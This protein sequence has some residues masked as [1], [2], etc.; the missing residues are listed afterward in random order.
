MTCRKSRARIVELQPLETRDVPS[1]VGAGLLCGCP[2]CSGLG[3]AGLLAESAGGAGPAA[4]LAADPVPGS[5]TYTRTTGDIRIDSLMWYTD[6]QGP[7]P[8]T[9]TYTFGTYP[10]SDKLKDNYRDIFAWLTHTNLINTRFEESDTVVPGQQMIRIE[11]RPDGYATGGGYGVR[12]NLQFDYAGDLNGWQNGPG[13]HGYGTLVHELGH[14]LGLKHSFEGVA[15]YDALPAA[16]D[17]KLNTV[18]AYAGSFGPGT[19]MRY[20]ALG[21]QYIYGSGAHNAGDTVYTF[22]DRIDTFPDAGRALSADGYYDSS[23]AQLLWD[24]G[25]TDELD[26]AALAADPDGYRMDLR[27]GG[28][29]TRKAGYDAANDVTLNGASVIAYGVLIENVVASSSSDD[30]VLNAAKN[31]VRG[32]PAG[33]AVGADT[34]F[35]ATTED[36]LD[37]TAYARAQ[38]TATRDGNDLKLTLGTN[39]SVTVKD[40]YAGRGMAVQFSDGT[41]ATGDRGPT[42]NDLEV[43]VVEDTPKTFSL[44]ASDPNGDPLTY[45]IVTG[46]ANGTFTRS[47]GSVTYTPNT[48][49]IGPDTFAFRVTAR[50]V[51]SA[52]ATVVLQ[53]RNVNDAPVASNVTVT[54]DPGVPLEVKIPWTD[55]DGSRD[56]STRIVTQPGF[57]T[58]SLPPDTKGVVTYTPKAGFSGGTDTFTVTVRDSDGAVSNVATVTVKVTGS[59]LAPVAVNDAADQMHQGLP[60]VLDVLANDTDGN[61]DTLTIQSV[62]APAKGTAAIANGKVTYTPAATATGTD[63]FTYT[64]SDGRGGTATARVD[65]TIVPPPPPAPANFRV[66]R[67]T[68]TSVGLAW[69]RVPGAESYILESLEGTVNGV[70]NWSRFATPNGTTTGYGITGF[71][72]GTTKTYRIRSVTALSGPSRNDSRVTFTTLV[73]QAPVGTAATVSTPEDTAKVITLAATDPDTDAVTF[74]LG[75]LP[76]NG[77]VTLSGTQVTYTP[78]PNFFG[79]DTFTFTASDGKLASA[80]ATVT[81]DVTPVND[82]PTALPGTLVVG[83][84]GT[85]AVTLTGADPDGDALTYVV[86]VAPA[87]GSVRVEGNQATYTPA[88]GYTGPDLFRVAAS[89]GKVQSVAADVT[90]TVTPASPVP[91]NPSSQ[92]VAVGSGASGA[93]AVLDS[94][95]TRTDRTPFPGTAGGVR[96]ASADVTGDGVPDLVAGRGPGG[97][98]TVVVLDG[99]TGGEVIRFEA[100]ETGFTGGVFVAAA[101]LDGDG[102]ADLVVSPDQGGGPIVAVFRGADLTGGTVNPAR[103]FG[104]QDDSFRGG[105]RVALGDL[106]GDGV[107]DLVVAAGFLGGPRVTVWDGTDLLAGRL[108]TPLANFFAF[109]DTLRNGTFVA[110]GDFDGDGV[111]ELA[112]GGGP[113]GGPRVRIVDGFALT[114]SPL[115]RLD[116]RLDLV[117]A[118]G[119]A[120]PADARGGVRLAAVDL[121]GD[122]TAELIAADGEAVGTTVRVYARALAA[123]WSEPDWEMNL[124]PDAS[125]GV[126]VG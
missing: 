49:F 115:S 110:V 104:I 44:P 61:G 89:D 39:G 7:G 18:M 106:T 11:T 71:G 85:G 38:V 74:A 109:E 22:T 46:P 6:P 12:L 32:Y 90:V 13:S 20:D 76:R 54:T 27:P 59:N 86:T 1:G 40:Y 73:N 66:T 25:G 95:R 80:P 91:A 116:D 102:F 37:L 101:D 31:R 107:P 125:A 4:A 114:S 21:L 48:D 67:L 23:T 14:A 26:F 2:Q 47:G 43:S 81:V 120:G 24:T 117:R 3:S 93:V 9:M 10:F 79:R 19:F 69:D 36:T 62:T 121:D 51:A 5:D 84:G 15:G 78:N 70:E 45:E 50:G 112:V 29:L 111:G 58:A 55:A 56:F 88:A 108:D 96:V 77:R 119:F 42:A 98:S 97:P 53:V 17:L 83:R 64:V 8:R 94:S 33:K 34:I 103:F 99:V 60:N 72:E 113:G 122:G 118:N 52:T 126:F 35:A 57:G 105:A 28:L 82:A 68:K 63:S 30:I 16:D 65:L 123:D 92:V 124:W 87:H 41:L 75:T 100:F